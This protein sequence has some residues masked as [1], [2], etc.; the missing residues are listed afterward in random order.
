MLYDKTPIKP[1]AFSIGLC[2]FLFALLFFSCAP[3]EQDEGSEQ[4]GES[5]SKEAAQPESKAQAETKEAVEGQEPGPLVKTAS[6]LQLQDLVVG[7]G[8]MAVPGSRLEVHYTGWLEDGTEFDSSRKPGREPYLVILDRSGVIQ[9]WHEG[10]RGMREGGKRKLIIPPE[11]GYGEEGKEPDI[12][13]NA[14][15]IFEVELLEVR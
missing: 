14:I 13:P 6:G 12:P 15:L 3:A 9:G 7:Q 1:L 11:L 8:K 10:L 5:E 2:T 4:T